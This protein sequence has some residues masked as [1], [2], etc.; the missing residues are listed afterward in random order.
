MMYVMRKVKQRTILTGHGADNYY[1]LSRKAYQ[2]YHGR[3]DEYRELSF[4]DPKWSQKQFTRQ[5]GEPLNKW[6]A[7][8]YHSKRVFNV[9]KGTTYEELNKPHQKSVSRDAFASEL[10]RCK[11]YTHMPFQLGDS[12]IAEH[13]EKLVSMEC[14][15]SNAKTVVGV[16]NSISRSAK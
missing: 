3:W 2:H 6:F 12:G 13:F 1:C 14:N 15:L 7:Y 9:F 5:F 16:Y 11:V 4:D 8:P 10:E